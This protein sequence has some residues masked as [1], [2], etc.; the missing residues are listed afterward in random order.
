MV[1]NIIMIM[2][3]S[4]QIIEL[5]HIDDLGILVVAYNVSSCFSVWAFQ[6]RKMQPACV[7]CFDVVI[8]RR[9]RSRKERIEQ[10][11]MVVLF[12]SSNISSK[13]VNC[14]LWK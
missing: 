12:S 9:E 6:C 4:V 11:I 1:K 7:E 2:F 14:S 8:R 10:L 5:F 13:D 3:T